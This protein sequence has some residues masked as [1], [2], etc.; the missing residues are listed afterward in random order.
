LLTPEVDH[1]FLG[2]IVYLR[3]AYRNSQFV[4]NDVSLSLL[5]IS[6]CHLLNLNL[7][8]E[9]LNYWEHLC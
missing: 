7:W 1:S 6:M 3:I 2:I 5:L 9:I 4:Q 8:S